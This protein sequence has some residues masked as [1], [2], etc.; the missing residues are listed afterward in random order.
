MAQA[1]KANERNRRAL[2]V[3]VLATHCT[4]QRWGKLLEALGAHIQLRR[5]ASIA[6]ASS[7]GDASA[8]ALVSF[9]RGRG[10]GAKKV[11]CEVTLNN[12]CRFLVRC[13][14]SCI[15]WW[16]F[17]SFFS[18]RRIVAQQRAATSVFQPR[19]DLN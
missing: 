10:R 6:L 12:G 2:L 18:S 11:R 15:E 13:I 9:M 8:K 19:A 7:R 4:E 5:R 3:R 1:S 16:E 14:L 17:S